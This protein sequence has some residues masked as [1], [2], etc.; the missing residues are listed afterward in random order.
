MNEFNKSL[1]SCSVVQ[2]TYVLLYQ[3]MQNCFLRWLYHFCSVASNNRTFLDKSSNFLFTHFFHLCML[4]FLGDFLTLYSV[5]CFYNCVFNLQGLSLKKFCEC[6]FAVSCSCFIIVIYSFNP[7]MILMVFLSVLLSAQSQFSSS[8]FLN[9]CLFWSL[10]FMLGS[11]LKCLVNFAYLLKLQSG[12]FK[13]DLKLHV[14]EYIVLLTMSFTVGWSTG[15]FS[16][17]TPKVKIVRYF[18]LSRSCF[19]R[20]FLLLS[21]LEGKGLDTSAP[22]AKWKKQDGTQHSEG[23]L[24]FNPSV[25]GAQNSARHSLS[26]DIR[27]SPFQRI[28]LQSSAKVR[29]I[30]LKLF[31][32]FK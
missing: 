22:G 23:T 4:S 1:F 19:P 3:V 25:S 6:S 29:E 8:S 9:V 30:K 11:F 2:Y 7:L 26:I 12:D 28:N 15:K 32:L 24:W 13:A 31:Q 14:H 20:K 10:S 5:F 18:P 27:S 16:S 21:C 17:G